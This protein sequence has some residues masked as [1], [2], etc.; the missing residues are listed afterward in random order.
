MEMNKH[1]MV[2]ETMLEG[3]EEGDE[4]I[5]YFKNLIKEN[6][7]IKKQVYKCI[8]KHNLE[9]EL[10]CKKIDDYIAEWNDDTIEN[11]IGSRFIEL[12]EDFAE[13]L[14]NNLK[15]KKE[16]EKLEELAYDYIDG[17]K[18]C[19]SVLKNYRDE[20]NIIQKLDEDESELEDIVCVAPY[21]KKL[22]EQIKNYKINEE[23]R[24][25]LINELKTKN[26]E[27]QKNQSSM[28]DYDI[29]TIYEMINSMDFDPN[30][31]LYTGFRDFDFEEFLENV[32]SKMHNDT[33]I[34][35][36][37]DLKE[38]VELQS[39]IHKDYAMRRDRM[40]DYIRK[41][42]KDKED[43]VKILKEELKKLEKELNI[44]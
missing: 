11:E 19:A 42:K 39:K 31:N 7:K 30:L 15:L 36:P 20:M 14:G 44:Y 13:E 2:I 26:I 3:N 27:L 38:A 16:N 8:F 1:L 40:Q 43:R 41:F 12:Q 33:M 24:E 32:K 10:E 6:E 34:I 17:G 9:G 5:E 37:N 35:I 18:T 29:G 4:T 25:L 28:T 23:S 21:I 22:K